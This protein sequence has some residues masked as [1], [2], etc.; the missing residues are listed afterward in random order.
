MSASD[1]AL[2]EGGSPIAP[3]SAG[4]VRWVRVVR[5]LP[6]LLGSALL[7]LALAVLQR[8]V[9]GHD[10]ADVRLYL[11]DLPLSRTLLALLCAAASYCLLTGYDLLALRYIGRVLPYRKVSFASFVASAFSNMVG[12][13][14]LSGGSVRYRFYTGWG[15]STGEVA[16]LIV[17]CDFALWLG[18]FA[19]GSIVLLAHGIALP[20][21]LHAPLQTARPL[22]ALFAVVVAGYFVLVSVRRR[23]LRVRGQEISLPDRRTALLAATLSALDWSL[24]ALLLFVLLPPLPGLGYAGFLGV[25]LLAQT[26][27]Q[28]SQVPGGLGVFETVLLL[29]LQGMVAPTALLGALLAYRAIYYLLPFT[30]AALLLGGRELIRARAGVRRWVAAVRRGL[31]ALAPQALAASTFLAGALLL[32]SGATPA[33]PGRMHWLRDILP[34]PVIVFSHFLGSLVGLCL[35]LLARGLQR[36][37]DGAYLLT[38]GML[39]AG[40]LF[41]L[42]KGF[43]YEEATVLFVLLVFLVPSRHHFF[44]ATSLVGER[45]TWGWLAAVVIVLLS[46]LYLVL[47]SFNHQEYAASAWWSVLF[48]NY[49]P[50]A[51]RATVTAVGL[52]LLVALGWLLRPATLAI[53]ETGDIDLERVL[54]AVRDSPTT[55]ATLALLGDKEILWAESGKSFLMYAV[56]GRSWVA[57]G[58]P[59][60]APEDRA[61]LVLRFR[62]LSDRHSGWCVFYQVSRD[63][64]PLY[65]DI[66]LTLQKLGE[67]AQVSLPEFSLDGAKRKKFRNLL[68]R[69]EREGCAFEVVPSGGFAALEPELRRVSEAWLG[70]KTTREKGFSLGYFEP[71]YLRHFDT[72]VVRRAGEVVAFGN[73]Q[74]GAGLEE[75]SVDLMRFLPDGPE[76][77]MEFMLL[78]LMLQGRAEGYRWFN[79][80]M[81]PL[82]GLGLNAY[83]PLWTRFGSLVFL[84]GEKVYN[85]Q[86]VRA[87]KEKFDP[88]WEPK[89]LAAP[90]GVVLPRVL[91]NVSVLIAGGLR[92]VIAR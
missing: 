62:E 50:R 23:P 8:E 11:T 92:G 65:L 75:L 5:L 44:R 49:A 28:L 45:F 90:G 71:E 32:F 30:I 81:A 60:G 41:S 78:H 34:I 83:S 85:F 51:L 66:N 77:C 25:F 63:N 56:A 33:A 10:L 73:I 31:T 3:P 27:G 57:L 72:A 67:E 82:S 88:V 87:Y 79:L 70:E 39:L 35:L 43:D 19:L 21:A 84:H 9:R 86:G 47:F 13:S 15:L 52:G 40:I 59:I 55:L 24:V 6:A 58:D 20:A 36:R 53:D 12:H 18:Y 16:R 61:E 69:L 42:L 37:L 22:G 26:I 64:L 46:A 38:V 4:A 48:T 76:Q 54:P 68:H 17:F 29:L 91:A 7:V 14:M 74:R 80:G 89:Y 2:G 1:S